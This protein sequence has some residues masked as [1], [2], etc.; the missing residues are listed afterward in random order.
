MYTLIQLKF[1]TPHQDSCSTSK[2]CHTHTIAYPMMR[3]LLE[4]AHTH[5]PLITTVLLPPSSKDTM[6]ASTTVFVITPSK[7]LYFTFLF[8]V[9]LPRCV[10]R[11]ELEILSMS[12]QDRRPGICHKPLMWAL[13]QVMLTH[14]LSEALQQRCAQPGQHFTVNLAKLSPWYCGCF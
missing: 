7:S 9:R 3:R 13:P 12:A 6:Q 11:W 1:Q 4:Q 14:P 10:G 8:P 2:K 5:M